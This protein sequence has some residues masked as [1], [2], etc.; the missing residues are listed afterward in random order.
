[1]GGR[2]HTAQQFVIHRSQH[3]IQ[4]AVAGPAAAGTTAAGIT[5]AGITVLGITVS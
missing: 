2:A 4:F 3:G 5:A 1:V